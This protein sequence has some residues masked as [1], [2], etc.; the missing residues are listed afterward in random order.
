MT[1]A[2]LF[3]SMSYAG[4]RARIN[5]A[6]WNGAQTRGDVH[7]KTET[8]MSAM[9]HFLEYGENIIIHEDIRLEKTNLV[10]SEMMC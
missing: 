4:L 3:A 9:F 10:M 6:N 2:N 1:M 5:C 8:V 7:G